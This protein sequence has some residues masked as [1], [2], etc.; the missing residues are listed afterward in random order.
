M[1]V[2]VIVR[3]GRESPLRSAVDL[4]FRRGLKIRKNQ[5]RG[6]EN[7]RKSEARRVLGALGA[8][9]GIFGAL[10]WELLAKLGQIGRKMIEVGARMASSRVLDGP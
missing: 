8:V 6:V 2:C 7:Q 10:W 1:H 4:R 9:L 3:R 5:P